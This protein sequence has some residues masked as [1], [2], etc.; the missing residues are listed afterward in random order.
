MSISF[1]QDKSHCSSPDCEMIKT[2]NITYEI[3]SVVL[4]T[5]CLHKIT[6]ISHKNLLESNYSVYNHV[7]FLK[8]FFA[9]FVIPIF[10]EIHQ[11]LYTDNFI[12]VVILIFFLLKYKTIG[13]RL[14]YAS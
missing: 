7:F 8:F 1:S 13:E 5:N 3:I 4:E 6:S 2:L 14:L 12:K 10:E 11:S 9:N